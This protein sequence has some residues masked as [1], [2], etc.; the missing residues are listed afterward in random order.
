MAERRAPR[1][2]TNRRNGSCPRC[3]IHRR[4][5]ITA[6]AAPATGSTSGSTA[7]GTARRGSHEG[8]GGAGNP[9]RRRPGR[10]GCAADRDRR[11]PARR[12]DP[13]LDGRR[14]DPASA[15][16]DALRRPHGPPEIPG[17]LCPHAA[18]SNATGNQH[19]G[20]RR[21]TLALEPAE[22]EVTRAARRHET[23][24]PGNRLVVAVL[25]VPAVSRMIAA[26]RWSPRSRTS[27]TSRTTC[28]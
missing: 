27:R 26:F 28:E 21:R 23:V 7:G 18:S 25:E 8:G 16:H 14:H 6:G 3:G 5:L 19:L 10:G 17:T 12:G 11:S 9:A 15:L 22:S 24:D 13:P 4:H 2:G 1:V 20:K